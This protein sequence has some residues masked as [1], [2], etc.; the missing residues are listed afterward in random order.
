MDKVKPKKKLGQHFLKDERIALR[1]VESLGM[2]NEVDKVI[3]IGPG[4][5][6]LTKYLLDK[7]LSNFEAH[8]VDDES[9]EYLKKMY[10]DSAQQFLLQDF[11]KAPIDQSM[12]II[13]NFPYNISS[14]I[15]FKVYENKDRVYEVVGMIQKEVADRIVSP[16]GNK[17]YGILSVLLKAFYDIEYLFT[18]EPGVFNPPPK[19]RSAVIRLKRNKIINLGCNEQLFKRIVKEGFQKRRKT[20]WNALKNL[21]LPDNLRGNQLLTQRAEQLTVDQFIVLTNLIDNH[22]GDHSL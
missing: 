10:P 18:V 16:P 9:V 6:V 20:L 14:Q 21:N 7:G 17:V 13:G 5:G 19:V 2:V 8:D 15:F 4:M 11:L 1:I 12:A 3:E 22:G